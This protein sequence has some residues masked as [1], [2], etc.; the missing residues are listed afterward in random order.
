MIR[1]VFSKKLRLL[2]SSQFSYV[3]QKPFKISNKELIILARKNI[4]P[5]P[6][7]GILIG[8]KSIKKA[9]DRN[10]IKRLI[11]ETFRLSQN[12]LIAMDYI[13]IAKKKIK[14]LDNNIILITKLELLWLRYCQI[15]LKR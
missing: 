3:F 2:N 8:C 6:R 14:L 9:H 7:I 13:V 1:F 12:K 4:L 15:L 11:R 10:R 5:Y